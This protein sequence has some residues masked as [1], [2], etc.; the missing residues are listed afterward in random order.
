MPPG[1]KCSGSPTF[2]R[3]HE[4]HALKEKGPAICRPFCLAPPALRPLRALRGLMRLHERIGVAV[5]ELALALEPRGEP[6][7]LAG[8]R[9]GGLLVIAVCV[10]AI[11]S[12][13]KQRHEEERGEALARVLRSHREVLSK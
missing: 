2:S 1:R 6:R 11:R 9:N 8:V 4:R 7:G 3:L 10:G 13:E 5:G 12:A